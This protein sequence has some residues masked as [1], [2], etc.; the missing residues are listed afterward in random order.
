M[1]KDIYSE[2]GFFEEVTCLNRFVLFSAVD[3]FPTSSA[4][5]LSKKCLRIWIFVNG[6]WPFFPTPFVTRDSSDWESPASWIV[7]NV[8]WKLRKILL[9]LGLLCDWLDPWGLILF[10]L[11]EDFL[12]RVIVPDKL[13]TKG[14][15]FESDWGEL[16]GSSK[17]GLKRQ[18]NSLFPGTC[19]SGLWKS[20]KSKKK[21]KASM[22]MR[23]NM[24]E[25]ENL[26]EIETCQNHII[27]RSL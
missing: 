25:C 14:F 10:F 12:S 20:G 26:N 23:Y 16:H 1:P 9:G 17:V 4:T 22:K 19:I 11:L 7:P 8:G 24:Y 2:L 5:F 21:Y 18:F 3:V 6:C 13:L 27:E 15:W